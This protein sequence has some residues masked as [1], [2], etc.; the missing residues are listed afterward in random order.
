M[1]AMQYEC[2]SNGDDSKVVNNS[3]KKTQAESPLPVVH[4]LEPVYLHFIFWSHWQYYRH[5]R[6]SNFEFV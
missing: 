5:A 3:N 2:T 4:F 6:Q 1:Y